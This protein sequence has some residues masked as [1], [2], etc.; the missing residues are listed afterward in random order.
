MNLELPLD[1]TTSA[2]LRP[3][4]KL[5][6]HS[7][8]TAEA[9]LLMLTKDRFYGAQIAAATGCQANFAG[10][11]LARFE[12]AGLVEKLP[13]EEGQLRRYYRRRASTIWDSLGTIVE[14]LLNEPPPE[15]ARLT[16][17][18]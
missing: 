14:E 3:V 8:Y 13:Q 4:S 15:V 16:P 12:S 7:E 18:P 9:I 11:L 1:G 17:R 5:L 10:S 6:F 2:R